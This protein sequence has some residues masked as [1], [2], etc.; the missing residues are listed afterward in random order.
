MELDSDYSLDN[1]IDTKHNL[2]I[3]SELSNLNGL[4]ILYLNGRSI[5]NKISDIEILLQNINQVVHL[6]LITETWLDK[7]DQEFYNLKNYI[8]YHNVREKLGGGVV[9]FCHESVKS[10]LSVSDNFL[11]NSHLLVVKL[12]DHNINI[13]T[14]YRAPDCNISD[15]LS[16]FESKLK[17]IKNVLY[18]GDFNINYLNEL[19]KNTSD[20][21]NLISSEGFLIL[22]KNTPEF[23]TRV[24]SNSILD[25]A[26]TDL[27]NF[28]YV[29]YLE[30]IEHLSD[31]RA[32]LLNLNFKLALTNHIVKKTKVNFGNILKDIENSRELSVCEDFSVF[33]SVLSNIIKKNKTVKTTES[34]ITKYKQNWCSDGLKTLVK[35]RKLY[36]DLRKKHPTNDFYT[37]SYKKIHEIITNRSKLDKK[38][39][40]EKEFEKN[41]HNPR[42]TWGLIN[43]IIYNKPK[44]TASPTPKKIVY[45]DTVNETTIDVSNALNNFFG[46]IGSDLAASS[47]NCPEATLISSSNTPITNFKPVTSD[48]IEKIISGLNSNSSS[49]CDEISVKILKMASD[50]LSPILSKLINKALVTGT[51]PNELK[52]AKVIPIYKNGNKSDPGNYRPISI[53]SNLSKIYELC[54]KARILD[55]LS[56]NNCISEYQFGF[57][58]NSST[59]SACLTYVEFVLKQIENKL[60]T[61]SIFIDI[62]KAFDSVDHTILLNKL[63]NAGFSHKAYAILES[64]LKD[65]Y[66]FVEL[67]GHRSDVLL[68]RTGVP[69]GSI[70]G[71]ILFNFFID[72]LFKIPLIGQIQLYADDAT[73]S[74][75]VQSF[76]ELQR[77]MTSDLKLIKKWMGQNKLSINFNKTNFL[78]FYLRNTDISKIFNEICFDNIKIDRVMESKYLGLIINHNL[79]WIPHIEFLK[80]KVSK[81]IGVLYRISKFVDTTTKLKIYYAF[82][83]SHLTYLNTIWGSA[84]DSSINTIQIL[85]N[86]AIKLIYNLHRLTPSVDLYTESPMLPIKYL[87]KF[88]LSLLVFKISNNLIKFNGNFELNSDN[89]S[90]VTRIRNNFKRIFSR[91]NV[92]KNS[93]FNR[94]VSIYNELPDHI[95][96]LNRISNFKVATKSHLKKEFTIKMNL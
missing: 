49:G 77:S 14:V 13:G 52:L 69:Q 91:N 7:N 38:S 63:K 51:F 65:R 66:Q 44:S 24:A 41:L 78:I 61:G 89:H 88:E 27:V 84:A 30:D 42:H 73:I 87:F 79:S 93:I 43:S 35:K 3:P 36:F 23:V 45:K 4:N 94:G 86:K 67:D 8:S 55:F 80:N 46:N 82:I 58:R 12:S 64:Y 83:H 29:F 81:F 21:R 85:Q 62:R 70:L 25:Y 72:D 75:G 92:T 57:Q 48:E 26:V 90:Y 39:Y 59:T 32:I 31:H 22:N 15:F 71:P 76:D 74:Y 6:I 5:R 20:F 96:I 47:D 19:S 33:S 9:I 60:K 37:T 54:L 34:L 18:I 1:Q 95:K 53:L 28:K 2:G 56:L 16:Y 10:V 17:A 40:Y 11:N 68:I 50:T